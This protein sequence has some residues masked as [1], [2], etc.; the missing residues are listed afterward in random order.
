MKKSNVYEIKPCGLVAS[1]DTIDEAVEYFDLIVNGL[2]KQDKVYVGT[3][4]YV[5]WNTLAENYVITKK[6]NK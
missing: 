3:A 1:R 2:D 5:L 4:F 6:E